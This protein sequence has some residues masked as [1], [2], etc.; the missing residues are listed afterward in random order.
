MLPGGLKEKK[1]PNL[2]LFFSDKTLDLTIKYSSS[3]KYHQVMRSLPS[4]MKVD[5]LCPCQPIWALHCPGAPGTTQRLQQLGALCPAPPNIL[6]AIA[7]M[8]MGLD[9]AGDPPYVVYP[10]LSIN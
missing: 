6:I 2:F 9:I 7:P 4:W 1:I 8:G 3:S 5:R 10:E